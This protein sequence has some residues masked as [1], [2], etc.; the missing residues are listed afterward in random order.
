VT[1]KSAIRHESVLRGIPLLVVGVLLFGGCQSAPVVKVKRPVKI[2]TT[3]DHLINHICVIL[4]EYGF[5]VE[6]INRASGSVYTHPLSSR[7]WFEFWR[8]DVRGFD[9]VS[10]SSLQDIR[11]IVVVT[12]KKDESAEVSSRFVLDVSVTVQRYI[13]SDAS[14]A[15]PQKPSGIF[16]NMNRVIPAVSSGENVQWEIVDRDVRLENE[17]LRQIAK[18]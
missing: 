6:H 3:S 10:E 2:T 16:P 11:R 5:K 17:L 9:E 4:K 12:Y 7:Q 1:F 18:N 8:K 15:T 13:A 14:K